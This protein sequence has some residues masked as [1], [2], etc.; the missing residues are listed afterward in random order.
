MEKATGRGAGGGQPEPRG[1]AEDCAGSH[2]LPRE[3]SPRN[4]R[5][6]RCKL[7][8]QPVT[9]GFSPPHVL[10][11]PGT[12][13]EACLTLTVSLFSVHMFLDETDLQ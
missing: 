13:A 6:P 12:T 7:T 4:G 1:G 2:T 11:P 3:R 8:G 10:F 5:G 9:P